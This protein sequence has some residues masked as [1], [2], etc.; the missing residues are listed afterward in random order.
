MTPRWGMSSEPSYVPMFDSRLDPPFSFGDRLANFIS[1]T[2]QSIV[3][4]AVFNPTFT[5]FRAAH[6]LDEHAASNS[7]AAV[8]VTQ[9]SWMTEIPRPT[10]PGIKLVGPILAAPGAP[11]PSDIEVF[12]ADAEHGVVLVSFGSVAQPSAALAAT[13]VKAMAELP[14]RFVVKLAFAQPAVVPEN[15]RLFKWLPQ[16]D[17]LAHPKL[18]AF[19][20]HGGLN[21]VGEATYHGVPMLGVPLFGDQWD[22]IMRLVHRK[23]ATMITDH[24]LSVAGW[25]DAITHIAT[26]PSFGAGVLLFFYLY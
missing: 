6:G 16:N 5:A 2:V 17:V 23:M 20:T 3:Q 9:M 26:D 21:S 1:Y 14:F 13:L 8:V 12:M 18:L 11:L 22:N 15:V 24:S 7:R 25:K 4:V 10:A 19:I